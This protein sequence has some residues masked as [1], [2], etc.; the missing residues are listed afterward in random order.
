M[1]NG[2]TIGYLGYLTEISPDDRRPA[3]SAYFNAMSSPAALLPLLGA[4]IV[5]WVSIG[6]VFVAAIIAALWQCLLLARID[7]IERAGT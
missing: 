5:S 4:A 7:R 2:I 1:M 6:A 3:Y